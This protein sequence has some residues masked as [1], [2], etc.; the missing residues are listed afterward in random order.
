MFQ[1]S[2]SAF[3]H[4]QLGL[5]VKSREGRTEELTDIQCL[6]PQRALAS[7]PPTVQHVPSRLELGRPLVRHVDVH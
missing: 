3:S 4:C 5:R 2:V 1:S 7:P 6:R